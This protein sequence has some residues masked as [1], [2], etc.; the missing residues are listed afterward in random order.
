[1]GRRAPV[2]GASI[3]A[4]IVCAPDRPSPAGGQ[5]CAG[6]DP[7]TAAATTATHRC[8]VASADALA[9]ALGT[10]DRSASSVLVRVHVLVLVLVLDSS[11]RH[12]RLSIDTMRSR[13]TFASF[14]SLGST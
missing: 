12:M 8:A 3:V 9:S 5:H 10:A 7:S 2:Q 4:S 13:R 14:A 11:C 6:S 1:M